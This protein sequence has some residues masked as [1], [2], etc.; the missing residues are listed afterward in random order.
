MKA[1]MAVTLK[2]D[3]SLSMQSNAAA[4]QTQTLGFSEEGI[5]T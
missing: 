1:A 2:I 4:L 3:Q 5:E